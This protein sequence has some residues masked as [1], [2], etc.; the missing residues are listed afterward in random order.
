MLSICIPIYNRDCNAL[1]EELLKQC[2]DLAIEVEIIA[3]DD[4]SSDITKGWNSPLRNL[5]N[6]VYI[7][8]PTNIGRSVIRNLLAEKAKYNYLLFLDCDVLPS[9]SK[10]ITN[11]SEWISKGKQ[12][13]V[14][15]REYRKEDYSS[16]T[17][18][19]YTYGTKREA[20]SARIRNRKPY[21]AFVTGNFCIQRKIALELKFE[22]TLKEYGHEDTLFGIELKNKGIEVLHIDNPVVHIG[23]ETNAIFLEKQ[24]KALTNMASLLKQGHDLNTV[25]LYV[26]YTKLVRLNILPF[27]I[28]CLKPF[29]VILNKVLSNGIT[30]SLIWFDI[31]RLLEFSIVMKSIKKLR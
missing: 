24:V 26:F 22:E 15:G 5:A 2:K 8:L 11:Y 27:F 16:Q 6:V 13:I 23:V 1:I 17:K 4:A 10:F 12:V 29:R 14:G 25:S 31:Y 20:K 28:F 21:N 9:N 30:S 7:E 3:I 19:H 18:L